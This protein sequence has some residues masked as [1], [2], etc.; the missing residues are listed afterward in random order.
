MMKRLGLLD[1]QKSLEAI[2]FYNHQQLFGIAETYDSSKF[3]L[4][5]FAWNS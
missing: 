5:N 1:R 4:V 3:D 2:A